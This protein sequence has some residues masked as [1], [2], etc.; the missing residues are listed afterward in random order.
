MVE[1]AKKGVLSED[2]RKRIASLVQDPDDDDEDDDIEVIPA[3]KSKISPDVEKPSDFKRPEPMKPQ[4]ESNYENQEE[5]NYENQ[6]EFEEYG[7]PNFKNYDQNRYQ[8]NFAPR[9][10]YQNRPRFDS[11][12]YHNQNRFEPR[13][14]YQGGRPRFEPRGGFQGGRP[15]FEPH[16]RQNRQNWQHQPPRHTAPPQQNNPV[17]NAWQE[18]NDLFLN[19]DS[20]DF[21]KEEDLFERRDSNPGNSAWN[22]TAKVV[23]YG[24]GTT[25]SSH[26]TSSSSY[27]DYQDT[28]SKYNE[29]SS[30]GNLFEDRYQDTG[31]RQEESR[32]SY[33]HEES[34]SR[35]PSDYHSSR[36]SKYSSEKRYSSEDKRYSSEDT[37]Y[38]SRYQE[39]RNSRYED[40]RSSRHEEKREHM[41]RDHRSRHDDSKRETDRGQHEELFSTRDRDDYRSSRR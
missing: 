14:G 15:R 36:D 18:R 30:Y 37:R 17:Q 23:D 33:R 7:R 22:P 39:S 12:S 20:N 6:D 8:R 3:K 29:D 4:E 32:S 1:K 26:A 28:P 13:G 40:T 19:P 24:H 38:Q 16:E 25:G 34:R 21:N 41:N 35:Y 11:H 31:N 10:G 9:G 27:R 2:D 5:S